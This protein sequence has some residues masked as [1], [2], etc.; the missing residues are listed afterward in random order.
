MLTLS[1]PSCASI[2]FNLAIDG[3]QVDAACV[4]V[5]CMH[6]SA[7]IYVSKELTNQ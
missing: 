4:Y 6:S 2:F 1:Q 5:E 7:P 3:L